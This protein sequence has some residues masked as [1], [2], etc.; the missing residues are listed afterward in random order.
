MPLDG[1]IS[2]LQELSKFY[3]DSELQKAHQTRGIRD[4]AAQKH[5]KSYHPDDLK[6]IM[7]EYDVEEHENGVDGDFLVRRK[8]NN[9][10]YKVQILPD[11]VMA[12]PT[13]VC[14]VGLEVLY[15]IQY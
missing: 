15:T 13:S 6:K 1:T 10:K 5:H 14:E 4:S 8:A 12:C 3:A 7:K 11:D 9:V 2:K